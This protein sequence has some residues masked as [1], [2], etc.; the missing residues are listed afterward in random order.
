MKRKPITRQ[1]VLRAI[2]QFWRAYH[3]PATLRELMH[4]LDF[5]STEAVRYHVR[6]LRDQGLI[7]FEDGGVR[8]I[9][10]KEQTK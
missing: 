3:Y 1:R 2:R 8:T 7:E 4:K 9:R 6:I 10:P 5:N